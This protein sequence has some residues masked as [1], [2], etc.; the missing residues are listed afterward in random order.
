MTETSLVLSEEEREFLVRHLEAA[1]KE[2]R[3]EEHR[4]R[5]PNYR[6]H[7]LHEEAVISALL[8]KLSQPVG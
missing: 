1:L 8:G 6:E 3:I 5:A 7:V 2:K 4:T